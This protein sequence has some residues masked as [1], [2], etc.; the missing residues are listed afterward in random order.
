MFF[1]L[2]ALQ[3]DRNQM[4]QL[5]DIGVG[6]F[7]PVFLAET[8]QPL[9]GMSAWKVAMAAVADDPLLANPSAPLFA[10]SS[11]SASPAA[12]PVPATP[13]SI[14]RFQL[15]PPPDM[16]DNLEESG[17]AGGASCSTPQRHRFAVRMLDNNKSADDR[18][19]FLQVAALMASL[20]HPCVVALL[21]VCAPQAPLCMLLEYCAHRDLTTFLRNA[22]P[23]V[24]HEPRHVFVVNGHLP[25]GMASAVAENASN[26]AAEK[27]QLS[28][29][30]LLAM[31]E[32]VAHGM[33]YLSNQGYV[34][35]DLASRNCLVT[36]DYR[37]KISDFGLCR[38]IPRGKPYLDLGGLVP[39]RWT[40]PEALQ[41]PRFYV[42]SGRLVL[43]GPALGSVFV[44]SAALRRI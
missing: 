22:N 8:N 23:A 18:E 31:A 20:H 43:R 2:D 27:P 7:G 29:V 21:G 32:Q 26:E 19:A 41:A 25:S 10:I 39:V 42:A 14:S 34:F 1:S 3:F 38:A 24:L 35:R 40:A 13:N 17:S 44:G 15:P 33:V 36:A 6:C 30:Q 9:P 11:T 4:V 28:R 5:E 37:V 16:F 12:T